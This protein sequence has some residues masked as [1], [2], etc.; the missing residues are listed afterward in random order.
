M[1]T[2]IVL[3]VALLGSSA[4]AQ[5]PPKRQNDWRDSGVH[6]GMKGPAFDPT[7]MPPVIPDH[8]IPNSVRMLAPRGLS[9]EDKQLIYK[10]MD[11]FIAKHPDDEQDNARIAQIKTQLLSGRGDPGT[12]APAIGVVL[13]F[14]MGNDIMKPDEHG[15]LIKDRKA[16]ADAAQPYCDLLKRIN[17]TSGCMVH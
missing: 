1:R 11:E 10:A 3:L 15:I 2:T 6:P 9:E 5:E 4:M 17:P 16:S 8:R 12:M 14:A 7:V 13:S